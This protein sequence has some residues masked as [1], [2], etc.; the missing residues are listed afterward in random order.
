MICIIKLNLW[1][2]RRW[3]GR[4]CAALGQLAISLLQ[5][6]TCCG[7]ERCPW[8]CLQATSLCAPFIGL[9]ARG[10]IKDRRPH[11]GP[12]SHPLPPP[13]THSLCTTMTEVTASRLTWVCVENHILPLN[14]ETTPVHLK[15]LTVSFVVSIFFE[16]C[17]FSHCFFHERV[18]YERQQPSY[19]I[20]A[21]GMSIEHEGKEKKQR[22]QSVCA[23]ASLGFILFILIHG[24]PKRTHKRSFALLK[25]AY[26]PPS[27]KQPLLKCRENNTAHLLDYHLASGSLFCQIDEYF[28]L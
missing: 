19:T 28:A 25:Y 14:I 3:R 23:E 26:I 8:S 12:V 13:H 21:H 17:F 15:S 2:R 1:Q 11:C 10:D 6:I 16:W 27:K 9:M 24:D 20:S 22:L 18:R 5:Y 7:S 4:R